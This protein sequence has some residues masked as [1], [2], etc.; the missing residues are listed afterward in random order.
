MYLPKWTSLAL[1]WKNKDS[2]SSWGRTSASSSNVFKITG[3][4][5][6]LQY[7]ITNW[8]T[9][10]SVT[11]KITNQ[12]SVLKSNIII[13]I[14]KKI[15]MYVQFIQYKTKY[16]KYIYPYL[17]LFVSTCS[18]NIKPYNDILLIS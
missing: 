13:N 5:K 4:L 18:N 15:Y 11:L 9:T 8:I 3:S 14:I 6:S 10:D 1:R 16:N 2:W 17:C 12:S 7:A